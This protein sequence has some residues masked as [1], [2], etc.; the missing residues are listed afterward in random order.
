MALRC[1]HLLIGKV[2]SKFLH[3]VPMPFK[4]TIV[5]YIFGFAFVYNA[6]LTRTNSSL[7]YVGSFY[8][9]IAQYFHPR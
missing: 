2:Q 1:Y 4:H 9:L 7:E 6:K 3:E 5:D 8:W